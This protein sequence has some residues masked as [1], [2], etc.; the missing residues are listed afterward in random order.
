[1][2]VYVYRPKHPEA[3]ENGMVPYSMAGPRHLSRNATNVISDT[4]NPLRHMGTGKVI[5]SKSLFRQETKSSGCIET[6][7]QLPSK[8][9]PMQL[10]RGQ[11]RDAIRKALYDA[12]NK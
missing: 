11:R 9:Q 6:G 10:D 5:D 7:D 3:D 2:T 1:M 12:R 4:M 8:R